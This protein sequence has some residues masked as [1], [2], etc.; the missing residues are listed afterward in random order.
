[1]RVIGFEAPLE[2]WMILIDP[3]DFPAILDM[4]QIPKSHCFP[5]LGMGHQ[6][7]KVGVCMP[8]IYKDSALTTIT[9]PL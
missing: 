9:T 6:P 2:T 8:I 1:M 7:E 4:C 3:G 5:I